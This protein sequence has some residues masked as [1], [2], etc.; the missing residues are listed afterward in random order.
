[1]WPANLSGNVSKKAY[2]VGEEE[3]ARCGIN[4]SDEV[5]VDVSLGHR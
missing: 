3:F 2:L 4:E 5:H 1:M